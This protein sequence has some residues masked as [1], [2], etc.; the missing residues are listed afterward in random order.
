MTPAPVRGAPITNPVTDWLLLDKLT[1]NLSY[2]QQDEAH[3]LKLLNGN[4][5]P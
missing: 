2:F 5:T 3:E 1:V 4:P